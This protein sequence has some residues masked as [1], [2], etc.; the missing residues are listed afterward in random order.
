M[1]PSER[2]LNQS[3]HVCD[4]SLGRE[5]GVS[6]KSRDNVVAIGDCILRKLYHCL[7]LGLLL[8][9]LQGLKRH[10]LSGELL[11]LLQGLLL[12]LIELLLLDLS[13]RLLLILGLCL[14]LHGTLST[15]CFWIHKNCISI[16][17]LNSN[18]LGILDLLRTLDQ[19]GI[20]IW[21]LHLDT[22]CVYAKQL[23]SCVE[24]G[25]NTTLEA[26]INAI[27]YTGYDSITSCI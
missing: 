2:A 3:G 4:K 16:L 17:V 18:L 23:I 25:C 8:L 27:G 15:L 21:L 10:L 7:L 5:N 24:T 26:V 20:R 14:R 19:N 11:L 12:R 6:G 22:N 1:S 13:L 9:L